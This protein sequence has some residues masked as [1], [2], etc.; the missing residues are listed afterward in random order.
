[1]CESARDAA[2]PAPRAASPYSLLAVPGCGS[3]GP[4]P[5]DEPCSPASLPRELGIH[6]VLFGLGLALGAVASGAVS[7]RGRLGG[8]ARRQ[9]REQLLQVGRQRAHAVE[10]GL[11]LERLPRLGDE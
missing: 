2:A 7:A 9:A 8:R 11:L 4:P 3:S 5:C 6:H 1:A 10:T